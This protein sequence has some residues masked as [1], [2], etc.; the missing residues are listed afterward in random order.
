MKRICAI[1]SQPFETPIANAKSC[2]PHRQQYMKLM[3]NR[4]QMK[5]D[6]SDR[7][8]DARIRA[9]KRVQKALEKHANW[10][11]NSMVVRR[12]HEIS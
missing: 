2:I 7:A 3:R 6:N 11:A 10:S 12:F 1:C 4:R 9:E 5:Y 8:K